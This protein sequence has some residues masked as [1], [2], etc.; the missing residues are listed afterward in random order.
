[1][2][3]GRSSAGALRASAVYK[4]VYHL[5]AREYIPL[6][7]SIRWICE[8]LG[9]SPELEFTGGKRGWVGD[10]PFVFLDV[11]KIQ[12]TGWSPRHTIR[13]SILSTV[14]WL[15]A[16]PWILERRS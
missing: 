1:M 10:N 12:A 6:T 11:S 9:L 4:E 5:G 13:E 3:N 2:I 7:D 15:A 8:H 14:D 16:N